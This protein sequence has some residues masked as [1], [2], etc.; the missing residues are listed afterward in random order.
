MIFHIIY[1]FLTPNRNLKGPHSP[2]ELTE[3]RNYH[4]QT[5][6]SL[7]AFRTAQAQCLLISQ[8]L[9]NGNNCWGGENNFSWVA[10][11]F[12]Q[13]SCPGT[14]NLPIYLG[15]REVRV[16][17]MPEESLF[18]PEVAAKKWKGSFSLKKCIYI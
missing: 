16:H 12:P 1:L 17:F 5:T 13:L 3:P 2:T 8:V 9:S 6:V 4:L 11:V 10:E 14:A 18:L 15:T 7:C